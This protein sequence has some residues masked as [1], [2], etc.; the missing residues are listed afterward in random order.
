MLLTTSH[1]SGDPAAMLLTRALIAQWQ[2]KMPFCMQCLGEEAIACA[3]A[4]AI[5]EGDMGFPIYQQ[6]GLLLVW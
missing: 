5:G 1:G 2:K 3:H 6:Q 4:L